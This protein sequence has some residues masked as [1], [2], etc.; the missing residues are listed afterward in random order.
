MICW[1][2]ESLSNKPA[3]SPILI[4]VSTLSPVKTHTLIPVFFINWIVSATSHWSLS[5]IAVDPIKVSFS[6]IS[7]STLATAS[8]LST[9]SSLDNLD[10]SAHASYS[11]T[12][13][14][15]SAKYKV[16]RPIL[17][18]SSTI[19]CVFWCSPSIDSCVRSSAMTLSAP[20]HIITI[21][22]FGSLKIQLILFLVLVNSQ[23][24][25]N[26]YF[27]FFPFLV[28]LITILSSASLS[29]NTYPNYLAALTSASSSGEAAL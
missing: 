10:F 2:I 24:F 1:S 21:L 18:K 9:T 5:S 13:I 15:L 27:N 17:A 22:P 3:D 8:S 16:L 12:G 28:S 23:M 26:W 25:N 6:S 29:S 14:Y 20:L 11:W 7:P 19:G 4:A